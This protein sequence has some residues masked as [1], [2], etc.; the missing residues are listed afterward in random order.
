[1][2]R[3]QTAALLCATCVSL[4]ACSGG[5]DLVTSGA[6]GLSGPSATASSIFGATG[7]PLVVS[8][9]LSGEALRQDV[10][11]GITAGTS[12]FTRPTVATASLRGMV[13]VGDDTS[14]KMG[15]LTLNANFTSNTVT[16]STSDFSEFAG[17]GSARTKVGDLGGSL[18]LNNG[19]ISGSSLSADLAGTL[20]GATS[21]A[22]SGQLVGGFLNSGGRIQAVGGFQG[23]SQSGTSAP[24]RFNN[25]T[26]LASE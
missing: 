11:D 25:G 16:G 21:T 3:L 19:V 1:M 2:N 5:S 17:T 22:I 15:K 12:S 13:G 18:A 4:S 10:L 26:F 24:V 8:Q 7:E 6:M 14:L 20:T 23:T 9:T